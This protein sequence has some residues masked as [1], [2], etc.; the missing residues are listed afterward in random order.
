MKGFSMS[1]GPACSCACDGI[2]NFSDP[3]CPQNC[4]ERFMVLIVIFK[5]ENTLSYN[6]KSKAPAVEEYQSL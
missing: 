5:Y 1:F 4:V 2:Y 6:N 3:R